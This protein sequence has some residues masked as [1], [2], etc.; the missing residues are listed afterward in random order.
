M[1][2]TQANK[3]PL[4]TKSQYITACKDVPLGRPISGIQNLDLT[5]EG[6]SIRLHILLYFPVDGLCSRQDQAGNSKIKKIHSFS[7]PNNSSKPNSKSILIILPMVHLKCSTFSNELI[8]V[9]G[10]GDR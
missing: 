1:I 6:S 7:L 4:A 10:T 9:F 3:G 2:D 8:K 5:F